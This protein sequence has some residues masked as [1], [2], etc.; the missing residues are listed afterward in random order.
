MFV[1]MS[2]YVALNI[3]SWGLPI[4]FNFFTH[5]AQCFSSRIR[6]HN[7]RIGECPT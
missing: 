1:D 7:F 6:I 4:L 5:H 3:T 2:I